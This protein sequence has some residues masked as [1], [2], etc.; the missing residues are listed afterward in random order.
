MRSD[1]NNYCQLTT[2]RHRNIT[3]QQNGRLISL[4]AIVF[5]VSLFFHLLLSANMTA[6]NLDP[7]LYSWYLDLRTYG[8]VPH[9]S[10]IDRRRETEAHRQRDNVTLCLNTNSFI[11]SF[12]LGVS[13]FGLGFERLLRFVTEMGNIRDLIPV[14]RTPGQ[15][16]GQF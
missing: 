1:I 5:P 9:G 12:A 13:G 2:I 14:P 7:K 16:G 8:T 15:A 3:L 11:L 4:H 10:V 6:H